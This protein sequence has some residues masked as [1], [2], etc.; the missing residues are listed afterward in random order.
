MYQED[1][2][3]HLGVVGTWG[4]R[5]WL[6]KSSWDLELL[7]ADAEGLVQILELEGRLRVAFGA[8]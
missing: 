5:S 7:E 3:P 1:T 8:G 2:Q 6:V 4:Q